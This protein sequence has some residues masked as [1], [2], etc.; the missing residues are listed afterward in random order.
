MAKTARVAG[1]AA[2]VVVLGCT[3]S[4]VASQSAAAVAGA[5]SLM[6]SDARVRGVSSRMV[7]VISEGAGRSK[8]FGG[9]VDWIGTTDGI[10]YVA[11]GQCGHGVQ[12]CLLDTM[13]IAGPNR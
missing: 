7:A 12:A 2:V 3:S 8:T 13:T 11:E 4:A 5:P 1:V 10:V 6:T 9:L